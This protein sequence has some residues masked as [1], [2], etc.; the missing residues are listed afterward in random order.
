V[1]FNQPLLVDEDYKHSKEEP[2]FFVL[3]KTDLERE[4]LIVFTVR[5]NKIRVISVRDMSRKERK[6]Y[7]EF[8]NEE[9]T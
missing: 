1:F 8:S 2:R 4:L 6:V 7:E 3:G 9:N 5:N